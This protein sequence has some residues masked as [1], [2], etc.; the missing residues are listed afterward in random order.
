MLPIYSSISLPTFFKLLC[1]RMNKTRTKKTKKNQSKCTKKNKERNVSKTISTSS[2]CNYFSISTSQT[3][4]NKQNNKQQTKK[5]CNKYPYYDVF[6][7]KFNIAL[8]LGTVCVYDMC[9]V[10]VEMYHWS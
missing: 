4:K 9:R 3:K 8:N 1:M 7:N 2:C 5:I 10:S 6:I